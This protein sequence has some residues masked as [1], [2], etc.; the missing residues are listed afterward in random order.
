M[1]C[2]YHRNLDAVGSCKSCGKG[3]CPECAVDLGKGLACRD[4]C[5]EEAKR[6]I[7]LIEQNIKISPRAAEL[8]DL[9]RGGIAAPSLF[10]LVIGGIFLAWGLTDPDRFQFLIILGVCFLV[11]G[12]FPLLRRKKN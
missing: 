7:N 3:L 2:F 10:N 1:K 11:F 4:Q 6:V 12:A 9:N 8:C 5:E